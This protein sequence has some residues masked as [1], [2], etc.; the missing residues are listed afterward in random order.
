MI[1]SGE[2]IQSYAAC[3]SRG[4]NSTAK[5][6]VTAIADG[7]QALKQRLTGYDWWQHGHRHLTREGEQIGMDFG[8]LGKCGQ[9]ARTE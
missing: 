2:Q 6:A 4:S 7:L 9:D 8:T 1:N 5:C 3:F